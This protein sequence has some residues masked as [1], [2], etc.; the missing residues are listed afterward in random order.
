MCSGSTDVCEDAHRALCV[1]TCG[2][3]RGVPDAGRLN[4]S[5][6]GLC[7]SSGMYER[8]CGPCSCLIVV[9]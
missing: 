4:D 2:C 1:R 5:S 3:G 8:S 7:D 6:S 9:E